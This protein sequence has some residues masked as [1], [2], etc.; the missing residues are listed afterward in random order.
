[1]FC[2]DHLQEKF[3]FVDP[4]DNTTRTAPHTLH[5][6]SSSGSSSSMSATS[7]SPTF[8]QDT[9]TT[10]AFNDPYSTPFVKNNKRKRDMQVT[11]NGNHNGAESP[12]F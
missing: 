11:F 6:T 1:M 7:N 5:R 12:I 8:F 4:I 10:S 9:T 3:E 2:R